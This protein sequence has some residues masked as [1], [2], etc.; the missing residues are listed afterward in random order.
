MKAYM[1]TG[2]IFKFTESSE[3]QVDGVKMKGIPAAMCVWQGVAM[4]SLKF[5]TGPPYPTLLWPAVGPPP[6][7][8]Y[9]CLR[10][11]LQGGRPVAIFH[12]FR[13]PTP[14]AYADFCQFT[15]K[16]LTWPVCPRV[17]P[18]IPVKE[19]IGRV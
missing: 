9:G 14:Y 13:H 11:G 3:V 17:K 4:D 16:E 1:E 12:P 10:S 5:Y 7:Q 6:K 18:K 8:P 2:S 15:N 19:K